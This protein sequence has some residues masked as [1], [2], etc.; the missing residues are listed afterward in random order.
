MHHEMSGKSVR[1]QLKNWSIRRCC[2]LM[3][4]PVTH[5]E[6]EIFEKCSFKQPPMSHPSPL[7]GSDKPSPGSKS[8][9]SKMTHWLQ[10]SQSSI[11]H[12]WERGYS[13]CESFEAVPLCFQ[14]LGGPYS[15]EIPKIPNLASHIGC[16]CSAHGRFQEVLGFP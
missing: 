10:Q 7:W 1:S 14:C 6:W 8:T 15:V 4:V 11:N 3:F 5:L 9:Y 13:P 16:D 2:Y 12:F